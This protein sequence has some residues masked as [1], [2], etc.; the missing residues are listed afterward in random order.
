MG[1]RD[2]LL[3]APDPEPYF[4]PPAQVSV[5]PGSGV[6][7]TLHQRPDVASAFRQEEQEA[8]RRQGGDCVWT[9]LGGAAV[10]SL[11]PP[12]PP[13]ACVQVSCL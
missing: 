13:W 7:A 6:R 3:P 4:L 9:W 2:M 8:A 1:G 10:S 5:V 12:H 11:R